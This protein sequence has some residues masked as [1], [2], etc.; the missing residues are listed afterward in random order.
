[1]EGL[2][3]IL[4]PSLDLLFNLQIKHEFRYEVSKPKGKITDNFS[5]VEGFLITVGDRVSL[6][7]ISSGLDPEVMIVDLKEKRGVVDYSKGLLKGRV[8]LSARNPAGMITKEAWVAVRASIDLARIGY[9]TTL[10]VY[11]EEDLL[12]FPAT[13]FAPLGSTVV[14]GQPGEGAVLVTVK[15]ST[16]REALELLYRG[17]KPS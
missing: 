6:E 15:E 17:F 12:G 7:A 8:L 3:N 5:G 10:I 2:Y 14:Y 11:G 9:K 4:D 13:I 1:M 16:K